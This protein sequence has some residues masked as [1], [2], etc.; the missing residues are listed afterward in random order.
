[1]K[2][3]SIIA[4]FLFQLGFSQ[5]KTCG[6]DLYM[7]KMQNDPIAK[8][9]YLDLQS[10]FE[11]EL[12]KLQNPQ[13]KSAKNTNATIIIPVA[14]HFPSVATNSPDKA[15]LRQLAQNQIDIINA[16]FNAT[17][18]DIALWTPNASAFYPGTNVGILNVQFVLATKNHP[19][20]TGLSNGQVAVTF[21]SN[22]LA[23]SN[24][25]TQWSNY[26]NFVV[27]NL[28]GSTVGLSPIGGNPSAGGAVYITNFTFGSGSGCSGYQ[29]TP[30]YNL[31][32]T[33]SHE[34]G[35]FFNLYHTFGNDQCNDQNTDYVND[36]PQ[37]RGFGGCA[38]AGE[39]LGCISGEKSL[40]VNYMDYTQDACMYMFTAGQ[41]TRIRAYYNTIASQFATNVLSEQDFEFKDFSLYPNPNNGSFKI[42]FR[43]E[44]NEE[45][46]IIVYDISGRN[47]YNK[48]FQNSES[49]DQNIQL[50][51]VQTGVYL[52]CIKNGENKTVKRI[53][54]E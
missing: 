47:I 41:V 18:S 38:L 8:Q 54:V 24:Y 4:L 53:V 30:G 26:L 52:I 15:C 3:K 16:D 21:G 28:G 19:A 2:L 13:N 44:T 29:P 32:R 7:Q 5:E 34:L 27:R 42:S 31:G 36:T 11:I 22:Y 45:I 25:D 9:K 51:K 33:L 48:T 6:T 40:T 39:I 23:N 17:N 46:E 43:P 14:V 49:F 35:H 20:G 10:R 1:M 50:E 37:C 12:L